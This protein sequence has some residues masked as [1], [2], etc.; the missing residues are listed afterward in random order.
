MD[1]DR[2]L[3]DLLE[4]LAI[5]VFRRRD[6]RWL[7]RNLLINHHGPKVDRA[8]EI[9]KKKLRFENSYGINNG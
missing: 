3:G 2:E 6:Y 5:P 7:N 9:V 4:E 1:E 8:L